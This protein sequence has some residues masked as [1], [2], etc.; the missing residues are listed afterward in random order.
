LDAS[1]VLGVLAPQVRVDHERATRCVHTHLVRAESERV[2]SQAGNLLH[3]EASVHGL[4]SNFVWWT[5]A[6][7]A[8]PK[9]VTVMS[10]LTGCAAPLAEAY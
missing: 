1:D 8:V 7:S 3:H 10:T 6:F 9:S 4:L 2:V 5:R